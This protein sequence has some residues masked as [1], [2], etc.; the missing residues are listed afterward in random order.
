VDEREERILYFGSQENLLLRHK[1]RLAIHSPVLTSAF[2]LPILSY[3]Q[4]RMARYPERPPQYNSLLEGLLLEQIEDE[5]AVYRRLGIF[6]C[7][8]DVFAG[9]TNSEVDC[10]TT[11]EWLSSTT[12]TSGAVSEVTII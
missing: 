6:R 12:S 3:R 5:T 2:C 7:D 8:L 11:D 10:A 1:K 9:F 4:E